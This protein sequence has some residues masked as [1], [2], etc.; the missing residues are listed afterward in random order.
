MKWSYRLLSVAGIEIRVHATFA[1]ALLIGAVEFGTHHGAR[2]ALF[3]ACL[4]AAI[5]FCVTLHELGHCLVARRFGGTVREI[6][7]L[8]IGGVARLVREPSRPVHELLVALAGPAVNVL[9]AGALFF[10]LGLD[11]FRL[12]DSKYWTTIGALFAAP[13]PQALLGFLL[14]GNVSLALFNMFPAFPMDGGRVLRAL[15]SFVLGKPR[16]TAVATRVGQI[17]A[18]G[19]TGC[20]L[21]WFDNLM[22][23][24]IGLLVFFAASREKQM[25]RAVEVLEDLTAGD[26]CD[27]HAIQLTPDEAVGDVI[28]HA[29]RTGQSLFPVV[30]GSELLGIVA[31][32]EVVDAAS[33]L[34]LRASVRVALRRTLPVTDAKTPLMEVRS[35]LFDSGLPVVVTD[36][37][38][39]LGVLGGEDFSRIVALA[40]RLSARGIR[41]PG[42]LALPVEVS[43]SRLPPAADG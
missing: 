27:L 2:G 43:A 30:Y 14:I 35:L 17:L 36:E 5:F 25:G 32:D 37:G 7:L 23:A 18:I 42:A 1:L 15:L 34:G 13:K 29:L 3:G 9:I 4:I 21:V 10:G 8:P 40:A 39:F 22:L 26:V 6:V 28:D 19:L 33:R 41:R 31:R 12:T 11:P 38:R 16:A 24:V 20:S